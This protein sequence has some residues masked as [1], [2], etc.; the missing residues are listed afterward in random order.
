MD[1]MFRVGSS[2]LKLTI[3][4]EGEQ[5]GIVKTYAAGDRINGNLAIITNKDIIFDDIDIVLQGNSHTSLG[6][7]SNPNQYGSQTFLELRQPIQHDESPDPRCFNAGSTYKYLFSFVIPSRLLPQVCT[8]VDGSLIHRAHTML[9]PT[10]GDPIILQKKGLILDDMA[11][12]M[13]SISYTISA[14]IFKRAAKPSRFQVHALGCIGKKIRVIPYIEEQPPLMLL[15][16]PYYCDRKVQTVKRGILRSIVGSMI[17]TSSEPQPLRLTHHDSNIHG[18]ASSVA[19]VKVQFVPLGDE[20][21]PSLSTMTSKLTASTFYSTDHWQSFPCQSTVKSFSSAGHGLFNESILLSN[22][23]IASTQWRKHTG[24]CS[25]H[26]HPE[27]ST[28]CSS[29]TYYTTSIVVP[30]FM[31]TN[32]TVVPTFHS[33]LISRSYSID[34]TLSFCTSAVDLFLSSISLRLPVQVSTNLGFSEP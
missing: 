32:K 8:H 13:S 3:T 30:I 29:K 5:P 27:P 22:M 14:T 7:P 2:P 9:P 4:L 6:Q 1:S 24:P 15:D 21:P 19:T 16:H 25:D 26:C 33:C 20:E 11:P 17:M 28:F 18:A 23:C 10:F 12:Q 31:P 34:I